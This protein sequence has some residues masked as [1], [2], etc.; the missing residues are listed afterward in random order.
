MYLFFTKE[1]QEKMSDEFILE[2]GIYTDICSPGWLLN[3]IWYNLKL[4]GKTE[5]QLKNFV[6]D[7]DL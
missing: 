4:H 2:M 5:T 7:I 6:D 3:S 1:D